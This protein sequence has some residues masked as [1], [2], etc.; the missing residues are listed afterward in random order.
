[1]I[2]VKPL[3]CTPTYFPCSGIAR[4]QPVEL[5]VGRV[6]VADKLCAPAFVGLIVLIKTHVG[7][8]AFAA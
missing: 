5:P 8:L 3:R 1:M 2:V 7:L 4:E 6:N